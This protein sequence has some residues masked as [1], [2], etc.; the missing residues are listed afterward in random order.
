MAALGYTYDGQNKSDDARRCYGDAYNGF[1]KLLTAENPESI[2]ALSLLGQFYFRE[3]V[4]KRNRSLVTQAET[5]LA[6]VLQARR[7]ELGLNHAYTFQSE[8]D[9]GIVL[10]SQRR[11]DEAA[12]LLIGCYEKARANLDMPNAL[13]RRYGEQVVTLYEKW[14]KPDKAAEWREKLK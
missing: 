6:E 14:G 4:R 3:A 7:R 10:L 8:S 9:L 11:Y 12:P 2:K 5:T 1:C 13:V